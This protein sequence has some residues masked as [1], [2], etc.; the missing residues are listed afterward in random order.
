MMKIRYIL[1][2]FIFIPLAIYGNQSEIAELKSRLAGVDGGEKVDALNELSA[3]LISQ[4]DFDEARLYVLEGIKIAKAEHYRIGLAKS[5][6]RMAEIHA[7]KLDFTNAMKYHLDGLRIKDEEN[8]QAGIARS[9]Y[10]IGKL[11]LRQENAKAALSNLEASLLI[12]KTL[13]DK[14]GLGETEKAIGDVYVFKKVYGK[15]KEHYRNAQ[16]LLI[17]TKSYEKAAVIA[18]KNAS[19]M[20]ETGDYDGA[21]AQYQMALELFRS[22]GKMSMAAHCYYDLG[23]TYMQMREW[24]YAWD[25][26]ERA[27]EIWEAEN[28]LLHLAG[29]EQQFAMISAKE[30]D[31]AEAKKHLEQ[32][33]TYL[34]KQPVS[35]EKQAI[36]KSIAETY[37]EIESFPEA[38]AFQL[39]YNQAR[40]VYFDEEKSK[41][42]L[43]LTTKYESE[44]EAE[45]QQLKIASLEREKAYNQKLNYF[46]LA[47]LG[48]GGLLLMMSYRNYKRKQ[49]DNELLKQKN[50]EIQQQKEEI[51]AKNL[52]L[53]ENN[54]KLDV[55]NSKLV[56]EMA[57][58]ESIEKSTLM[59]DSFLASMSNSMRNPLNCIIGLAHLLLEDNPRP[60]QVE[61]LRSMQYSANNMIVYIN[62][63]LDFSKI[64]A[65]KLN[66]EN[67]PF[68]P[69]PLLSKLKARFA[70]KAKEKGVELSCVIDT[71]LPNQLM[72]DPARLDQ[73]LTQLLGNAIKYTDEGFVKMAAKLEELNT[74]EAIIKISVAD[75]GQGIPAEKLAAIFNQVAVPANG[76]SEFN[77]YGAKPLGLAMTKRLVELQ[78]GRINATSQVGKGSNFEVILPIKL[79]PNEM[80]NRESK[81]KTQNHAHLTGKNILLVEDNKINQLVVSK[82]LQKLGVEVTCANN[83]L[84][85]VDAVRANNF[86]LILMDIQMPKMDGYRATAE[87]RKMKNP[88]K[89]DVPI[90]A[91]TA[92]AFLSE[93]E[94]ARLF[95]MNDHVGKPFG[96]DD[97][98]EK[99]NTCL[100]AFK[101]GEDDA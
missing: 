45:K 85:A 8:D 59:R 77:D 61:N 68:A 79:I 43:E 97:L 23:Q 98:L 20:L 42:L 91:L 48:L 54:A 57:E 90:I 9:K 101:P 14:A 100:M 35:M 25:E 31:K 71:K 99:L 69:I 89:R 58:R 33:H 78:N 52:A 87:I 2:A 30:G 7:G 60:D 73:I 50:K 56:D 76:E 67:R 40:N 1:I 75:S 11:F 94:K 95:G 49:K 66:L 17:E 81:P 46:L 63:V 28:D 96:P 72:G 47:L 19:I 22:S 83:G 65:G 80:V 24:E 4:R 6:G 29:C 15:A 84:E 18:R 34:K 86:D 51:N 3:L 13:E 5:Y 39:K 74:Q 88:Q 93:K 16:Q 53:E 44:F 55:L 41:A 21:I 82:M 26:V 92:S 38:Y 64:E 10:N 36:L 70:G 27:A 37:N 12:W 32:S 62:D